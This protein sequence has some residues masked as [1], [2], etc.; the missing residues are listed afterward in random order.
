LPTKDEWQ[1][2]AAK[3]GG[4][5]NEAPDGGKGAYAALITGGASGFNAVLGGAREPNGAYERLDAH[6]LYWTASETGPGSAVMLNFAKGSA[7]LF[8][9]EAAP[10][11]RAGSVRCVRD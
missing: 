8:R 6:G 1:L 11:T 5:G 9:A 3:Y 4:V 7:A 2:L 10:K